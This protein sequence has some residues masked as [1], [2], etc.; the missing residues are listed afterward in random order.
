MSENQIQINYIDRINK[1]FHFI[2]ENL[3]SDLS[4]NIVSK[5][6]YFSPFHFH[7]IFK[8]ATGETL[9]GYVTRRRVEK[10]ASILIHKRHISITELSLQN[11][12]KENS[13]F[14]RAFKKFYGV[15]P[16]EFRKQNRNKVSKISQ[17][18]SK[19]GQEH[20]SFEQYI[21]NITNLKKWIEMNAKIK[22]KDMPKMEAAYIT[23]IGPQ[24]LGSAF[25]KLMK[26][27]IPNGLLQNQE[28]K[29]AT[30]YHDSFKITEP[31]KVRMSACVLL[32][33]PIETYGEIGLTR[34]QEGRF[35]V[36]SFKIG[37]H[38]FEKSWTGLFLWMNENGYKKAD[39]EP[40]EIYHNNFNEHPEKIC[41]VDF[42]IPIE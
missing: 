32:S 23:C 36:G 35:I 30:I 26:W 41:F 8:A 3:D 22:I 33:E 9:N 16:T 31:H 4:L 34:I 15:S 14:T 7:R 10:A 6:A 11:G 42:Y 21:C 40:F 1:V 5:I 13:S 29:V 17:L 27:A 25:E 28:A 2:D 20:S 38:E 18:E 19:N 24:N 12:F 37:V 39:R